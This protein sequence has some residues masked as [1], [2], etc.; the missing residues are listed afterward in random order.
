MSCE[1]CA[2]VFSSN[3]SYNDHLLT[4]HPYHICSICGIVT[5]S[6]PALNHHIESPHQDNSFCYDCGL[7]FKSKTSLKGHINRIHSNNEIKKCSKCD[8]QR[9]TNAQVKAHFKKR[10]T[11]DTKGICQYCGEVFRGL[12]E[13]LQRTGCGGEI[14]RADKIPCV[15]CIKTFSSRKGLNRHLKEIHKGVKD[16][17]CENCSYSTN[18]GSNLKLHISKVHWGKNDLEEKNAF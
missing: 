12:K 10:H 4:N 9:P 13:H 1:K 11:D 14:I 16:K 18:S 5:H 17:Q 15:Q 6:K 7:S 8:F 3:N 2:E